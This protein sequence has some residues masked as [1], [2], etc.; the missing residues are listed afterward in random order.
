MKDVHASQLWR[1]K[2]QTHAMGPGDALVELLH[3]EV[4]LRG[5]VDQGSHLKHRA[6]WIFPA[7]L[8]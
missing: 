3:G 4:H 6:E 1:L 8:S 5:H 7:R 2:I